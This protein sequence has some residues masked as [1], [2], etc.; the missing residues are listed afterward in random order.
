MT[1]V[2]PGAALPAGW[3][4][5]GVG[6][7]AHRPD[8]QAPLPWRPWS[9]SCGD[10]LTAPAPGTGQTCRDRDGFPVLFQGSN[11]KVQ[12]RE[13]RFTKL[14]TSPLTAPAPGGA[15]VRDMITGG[16]ELCSGPV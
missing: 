14:K 5:A 6:C 4:R 1:L 11:C 8:A 3:A 12:E 15:G 10:S 9:P 7:T 16:V 2:V 13:T